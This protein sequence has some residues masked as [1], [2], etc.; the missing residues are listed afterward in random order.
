MKAKKINGK[1][2]GSKFE[3]DVAKK[4]SLYLTDGKD[5]S[6]IW[7][8]ISS[9]AFA[10]NRKKK[11]ITT[12]H[13]VG[14]LSSTSEESKLFL[15]LF[16]IE[17]KSYKK[18][19]MYNLLTDSC[20]LV[21]WYKKIYQDGLFNDINEPH[22]KLPLV[23]F[24]QDFKPVLCMTSSVG[25]DYLSYYK[26]R[27]DEDDGEWTDNYEYIQYIN[28]YIDYNLE[29]EPDRIENITIF[30]F[31]D[32]FNLPYTNINENLLLLQKSLINIKTY[33]KRLEVIKDEEKNKC[34][35]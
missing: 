6:T 8:S 29:I 1:Q 33:Q 5:D 22:N 12:Q 30:K 26:K 7:R 23:I 13:N 10:T 14:D 3:R 34:G 28:K 17:C 18:I 27:L 32:L 9:G 31:D 20:I 35:E 19:D 24:K 4:L 16:N 15:S 2:K 11:G 21:D 25:F